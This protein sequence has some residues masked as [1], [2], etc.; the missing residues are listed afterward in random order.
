MTK[1]KTD[2]EQI[3]DVKQSHAAASQTIKTSIPGV[4]Q[5]LSRFLKIF[6]RVQNGEIVEGKN[7]G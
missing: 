6:R 4:E 1:P 5:T 2:L 3:S 7:E